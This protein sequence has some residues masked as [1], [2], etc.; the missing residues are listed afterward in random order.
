[1]FTKFEM[2]AEM[3]AALR[4]L[5]NGNFAR[6]GN[7]VEFFVITANPDDCDSVRVPDLDAW[8]ERIFLGNSE[9]QRHSKPLWESMQSDIDPLHHSWWLTRL[10]SFSWKV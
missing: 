7:A 2:M 4:A 3:S 9:V 10:R 5:R 1:M 8:A 6:A